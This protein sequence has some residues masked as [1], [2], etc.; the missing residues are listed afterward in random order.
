MFDKVHSIFCW[1][2]QNNLN[3]KDKPFKESKKGISDSFNDMY[4]RFIL[5]V[6]PNRNI[7][8]NCFK[9]DF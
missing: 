2:I 4:Y 7:H 1:Y 3:S 9:H 5:H 6:Y 8:E